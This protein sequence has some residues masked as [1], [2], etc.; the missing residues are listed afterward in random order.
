MQLSLGGNREVKFVEI[1][2]ADAPR[3]LQ[4]TWWWDG[5]YAYTQVGGKY[6]RRNIRLHRFLFDSPQGLEIDHIDGDRTNYKRDNLRIATHA[7]NI[8][9]SSAI[10]GNNSSGFKGVSWE[11]RQRK[12][13]ACITSEQKQYNL[14][15]YE[16]KEAAA[17]A[18]NE[19]ALRI[20][21]EFARLNVV[22]E[23]Q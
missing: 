11:K 22:G 9:N 3:V 1:D 19:A 20:F 12:W 7:Q 18:Y 5:K 16:T 4:H 14:G 23:N 8:A 13:Y 2:E 17:L 15:Y 21:G 10:R 6:H